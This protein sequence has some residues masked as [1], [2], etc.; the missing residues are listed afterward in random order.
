M[1]VYVQAC[2]CVHVH[3]YMHVCMVFRGVCVH[4]QVHA[5]LEDIANTEEKVNA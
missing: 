3:V 4:V 1:C 5:C 2:V